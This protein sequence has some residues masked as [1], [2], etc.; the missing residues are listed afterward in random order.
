MI[1]WWVPTMFVG[2]WGALGCGDDSGSAD[3]SGSSDGSGSADGSGSSDDGPPAGL[4]AACEGMDSPFVAADCL[5]GLRDRCRA[6]AD[7]GACTGAGTLAFDGGFEI[8]CGWAKVVTFSDVAA[9]TIASVEGRCEAGIEQTGLTCPDKCTDEPDLYASLR[10]DPDA[11]ELIEMPCAPEGHQLDGP[12]GPG[13]A[14]DAPPT[15]EGS[16]CAPN[17]QPPAPEICTCVSAACD[18]E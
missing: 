11:L 7:E 2:A 13:S 4:P 9:C 18:A 14:I 15:D 1:R 12:L 10:A 3:G 5:G 17:I 16:T 8:T 6:L